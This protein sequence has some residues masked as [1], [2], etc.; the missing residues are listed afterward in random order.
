[1]LEKLAICRKK[2][3]IEAI[4]ITRRIKGIVEG[5]ALMLEQTTAFT[6]LDIAFL[7]TTSYKRAVA[8]V[9]YEV[10]VNND[11]GDFFRTAV[12]VRRL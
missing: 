9:I 6:N 12:V 10:S 11:I 7:V 1:M 8:L 2:G 4:Y 3:R 5:T